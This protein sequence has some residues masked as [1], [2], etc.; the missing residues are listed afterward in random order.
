M[1]SHSFLQEVRIKYSANK[2]G[3]DER[4]GHAGLLNQVL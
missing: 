2:E 4:I 3:E 1:S